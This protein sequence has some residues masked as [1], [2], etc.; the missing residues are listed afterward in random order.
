MIQIVISL[1][2]GIIF[3]AGL[4]LSKLTNPEKVLNFL[5]FTGTW[6]PTPLFVLVPALVIVSISYHYCFKRP[7]PLY[8]TTFYLPENTQID[9]DLII[10]AALFG[11]GW[12]IVGLCPGPAIAGLIFLLPKS[13]AFIGCLLVGG[14]MGDKILSRLK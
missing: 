2:S 10:G 8:A 4:G 1:F 7:Q 13:F 3:G 12:G 11:I 9:S 14:V 6:D 5:D